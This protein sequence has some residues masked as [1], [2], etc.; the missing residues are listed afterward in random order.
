MLKIYE[1]LFK[2]LNNSNINYCIYKGLNHLEEDLNGE[3]GD[4]DI[5]IDKND[6]DFLTKII[7]QYNFFIDLS[8]N[9]PFY[10]MGIDKDT[11]KFTMLDVNTKIQFGPKPYKPYSFLFTTNELDIM[12]DGVKILNKNDYIPLMFLMRI[13]SLSEKKEDLEEIKEYLRNKDIHDAFIVNFINHKLNLKWEEV[14]QEILKAQDWKILKNQYEKDVIKIA[15]QDTILRL[16]QKFK[17]LLGKIRGLKL[18]LK[19]PP[20]RI[21]KK[22]H[23]IAFVGVDGAGKSS[24]VEYIENLDFFKYTGVKRIYFGNNE[25]WIPGLLKL[26]KKPHRHKLLNILLSILALL[27]RQ[28]RIFI[29]IYYMKLGNVVLADRYFYDDMIGREINKEKLKKQH[30]IKKLYH[31]IFAIKMLKKP[32]LTIFLDVSPE[33]AYSRKQDYSYAVMLEVNK[34]YK[35][36]MYKVENVMIVNADKPQK[37]IYSDVINAIL[38]LDKNGQN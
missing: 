28:I 8:S 13:T 4:I 16:K 17:K 5:L 35:D 9:G 37:E 22:G 10:Y 19:F 32:D 2:E 36:Y 11:H 3:R 25:Y 30:F 18:K 31:K 20:Y 27:D 7:K 23:L 6:L 38:E 29:A 34:A 26:L 12:T 1:K 21:R 14:S 15:N 24:T 33:V